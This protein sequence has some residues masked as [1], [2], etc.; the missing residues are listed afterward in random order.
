MVLTQ[1]AGKLLGLFAVQKTHCVSTHTHLHLVLFPVR[2][3]ALKQNFGLSKF[4]W[5]HWLDALVVSTHARTNCIELAS[6]CACGC[7]RHPRGGRAIDSVGNQCI[8]QAVQAPGP[9][10]CKKMGHQETMPNDQHYSARHAHPRF[11]VS[12]P[13]PTADILQLQC[14]ARQNRATH[15]GASRS[16]GILSLIHQ[17][18]SST[19]LTQPCLIDSTGHGMPSLDDVCSGCA[20]PP[21]LP[22]PLPTSMSV[23][24]N[25]SMPHTAWH[26]GPPEQNISRQNCPHVQLQSATNRMCAQHEMWV[27]RPRDSGSCAAVRRHLCYAMLCHAVSCYAMLC[28]AMPCYEMLCYATLC[29]AMPSWCACLLTCDVSSLLPPIRVYSKVTR[30]PV[31][32]K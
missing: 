13:K 24:S 23:S 16:W 26:A 17:H 19:V 3:H 11:E 10:G 28:H 18:T 4:G 9:V 1:Q 22:S 7:K 31:A 6:S 8:I 2:T 25:S 32:L 21:L 29:H 27:V 14:L 12:R 20:P 15:K 30:R 5:L